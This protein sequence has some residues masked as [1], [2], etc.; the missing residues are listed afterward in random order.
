[1]YGQ[2]KKSEHLKDMVKPPYMRLL[3]QDDIA[4]FLFCQC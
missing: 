4:L 3:V 2:R 1:M